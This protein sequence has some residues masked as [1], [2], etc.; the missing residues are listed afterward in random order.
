MPNWGGILF[1]TPIV[2]SSWI[3]TDQSG[4]YAISIRRNNDF[5][6]I[7][8][9]ET[10]NYAGRGINESHHAYDCWIREAGSIDNIYISFYYMHNSTE[11]Q[12][13][14]IEQRLIQQFNTV[15]ND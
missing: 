10:D 6:P 7:Y 13:R 12:R 5:I 11:N 1:T 8:F 2:L 15:C 14:E 3:P 9:G 4:I